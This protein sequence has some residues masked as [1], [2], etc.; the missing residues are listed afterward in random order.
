MRLAWMLLR[1]LLAC[2]RGLLEGYAEAL[3]RG[4]KSPR[5][6]ELLAA[7]PE[8]HQRQAPFLG[9][10]APQHDRVADRG[11]D[12]PDAMLARDAKLACYIPRLMKVEL[13]KEYRFEAAHRLP[14]VPAG[15]KC[16]RLHGHS[17]KIELAVAG[18]VDARSGWFID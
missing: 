13:V 2:E 7:G 11:N 9:G 15:H 17:F 5:E 3:S 12:R 16:A 8:A 10:Q 18:P 14:H 6:A 1:N 4:G